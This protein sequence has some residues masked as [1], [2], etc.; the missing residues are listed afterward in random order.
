MQKVVPCIFF[1]LLS[2]FLIL[3]HMSKSLKESKYCD[4]YHFPYKC[5]YMIK[6]SQKYSLYI[7]QSYSIIPNTTCQTGSIY[8]TTS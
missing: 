7:V 1:Y 3:K 8:P 4:Q 6:L 5:H 2:C